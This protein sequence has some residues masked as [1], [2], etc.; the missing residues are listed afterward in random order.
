VFRVAIPA[1]VIAAVALWVVAQIVVVRKGIMRL[2]YYYQ[3]N[4]NRASSSAYSLIDLNVELEP[5][6]NHGSVS[7]VAV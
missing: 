3:D 2:T 5:Y 6:R 1:T 4:R 7:C